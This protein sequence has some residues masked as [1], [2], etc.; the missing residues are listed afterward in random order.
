MASNTRKPQ[1]NSKRS[2]KKKGSFSFLT[3]QRFLLT[4]AILLF[5]FVIYLTIAF[6]SFIF[7][8]DADQS[9]LDIKWRELVFNPEIQVDL[10]DT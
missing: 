1:N 6:V 5:I 7:S 2:P 3:D 9:K 4:L 10:K 8:G